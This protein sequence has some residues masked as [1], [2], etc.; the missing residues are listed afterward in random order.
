M[1]AKKKSSV[2]ICVLGIAA[3]IYAEPSAA[4]LFPAMPVEQARQIAV[5]SIQRLAPRNVPSGRLAE[6]VRRIVERPSSMSLI[7]DERAEFV[8]RGPSAVNGDRTRTELALSIIGTHGEADTSPDLYMAHERLWRFFP[9]GYRME[10]R[11]ITAGRDGVPFEVR[12][13]VYER[14]NSE[15]ANPAPAEQARFQADIPLF[16]R[17][18]G[19][20]SLQ[21]L[22]DKITREG[23]SE[24]ILDP[25][26]W[27]R[28]VVH[29]V[30]EDQGG[31]RT[32]RERISVRRLGPTADAELMFLARR[33]VRRTSDFQPRDSSLVRYS[34]RLAGQGT[35]LALDS[36]SEINIPH[37]DPDQPPVPTTAADRARFPEIVNQVLPGLP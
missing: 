33:E 12:R 13:G 28:F 35:L 32:R 8:L 30:T 20:P 4:Q 19:T 36:S 22:A 16:L 24:N 7:D 29:V 9:D 23:R 14:R 6:V 3:A 34:A 31:N 17:T 5:D 1:N 15:V 37:S 25:E 18:F 11:V 27:P 2:A 10:S 26:A 21:E